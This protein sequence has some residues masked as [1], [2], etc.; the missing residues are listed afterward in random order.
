MRFLP[1]DM[2]LPLSR[3]RRRALIL[4]LSFTQ[5]TAWGTSFYAPSVLGP[6]LGAEIGVSPEV[7]FGGVTV[8]LLVSAALSPAAGRYI[9]RHGAR[10][11]A[12]LGSLLLAA[13][14]VG[15]AFSAG[16]LSYLAWWVLAGLATPLCM[17]NA[18]F[19][20]VAQAFPG[21][22]RRPITLLMLMSGLSSGIYWPVGG[23]LLGML[24]WRGA[25]IVFALLNL[26]VCLPIHALLVRRASDYASAPAVTAASA[27]ILPEASHGA[28]FWLLVVG[29]GISGLASWGLP[30]QFIPLFEESGMA[31]A[32]AVL[33]ASIQSPAGL[34]ARL[35]DLGLGPRVRAVALVAYAAVVAPL[36]F[37]GL[38]WALQSPPVTIPEIWLAAICV[39]TYGICTGLISTARATLPLELFGPAS[40][41]TLLGRLSLWLNVAFALSPLLFATLRRMGGL[42]LALFTGLVLSLI[43]GIAFARLDQ[44]DRRRF[45][46]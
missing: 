18:A 23:W 4:G 7:Q 41:A 30:L 8:M 2:P 5:M 3:A 21:E 40:Y 12:V 6:A 46:P 35:I 25:F 26:A 17:S 33:V 16:P 29:A 43:A 24:G 28:A 42:E 34:S 22:G 38:W 15:I 1:T 44:I 9:D 20:A 14:L 37:I 45:R 13:G 10:G 27:T 32:T 39:V 19:A 36:V 11:P 31:A